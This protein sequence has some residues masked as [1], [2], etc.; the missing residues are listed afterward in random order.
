MRIDLLKEEVIQIRRYLHA[1]PELAF[2]EF[3]TSKFIK[4]K[5]L[6]LGF[7][8]E[9]VAHTSVLGFRKGQSNKRP[10]CFRADMDALPI[11]ENTDLSFKSKNENMHGCGHDAH[12][13]ILLGF[14][15]YLSKLDNIKRDVVLIFQPGEENAGGAEVVLKDKIFKSYNIESIF[16]LHVQPEIDEGKIGLRAGPFMAQTIEFNIIVKGKSSHGAQPHKGV[17]ALYVASQLL[18]SYQSIISRSIDPLQ[19]AVLTIGRLKGGTARNLIAERAVLEGTLRTFDLNIYKSISEKM[20][21]INKG[22]ESMYDVEIQTEFI[23]FCPPVINDNKLFKDFVEILDK[24]EFVEMGPMTI[25]EDFGFYQTEYPGLFFMLGCRNEELGYI[26]PL[27]N[28][29][30]N[31]NEDILLKGLDMYI[32][33]G[34][35]FGIL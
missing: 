8:V 22:L 7:C 9:S 33:I 20:I 31:F 17:D 13:A 4:N 5:L 6:E 30:F 3:E 28:S 15:I 2:K 34:K 24:D 11:E 23:D 35:R 32:R 18:S 16:G 19:P 26:Y 21:Q 25:S 27:H 14:A 29:K 1:V 10:I 12:M